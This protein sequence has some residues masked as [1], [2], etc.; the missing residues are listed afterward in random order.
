MP[1]FIIGIGFATLITWLDHIVHHILT[2]YSLGASPSLIEKAYNENLN[3]QRPLRLAETRSLEDL[4]DKKKF[5]EC[6]SK[7]HYYYDFM[8]FFQK[9]ID[10]KG[11][12]ATL[13]EH[14]FAG[15]EH[16]DRMFVRLFAGITETFNVTPRLIGVQAFSIR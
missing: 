4:S 15:D 11:L 1:F 10:S 6:L 13:S 12:E 16:A 8:T 5:E 14:V 2:I 3:Y 7:Q 9:E